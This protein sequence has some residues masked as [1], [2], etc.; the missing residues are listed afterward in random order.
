[1]VGGN[2]AFDVINMSEKGHFQLLSWVKGPFTLGL[3]VGM[4][5]AMNR[6]LLPFIAL[7]LALTFPLTV[8][9]MK[10]A[11]ISVGDP[12]RAINAADA[13]SAPYRKEKISPSEIRAVRCIG[14]D[15]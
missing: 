2:P 3:S 14:P 13:A 9:A 5:V 15:E 1:M 4:V 6:S 7:S 11:N 12:A 8:E 10:R